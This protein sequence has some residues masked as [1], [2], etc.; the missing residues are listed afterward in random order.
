MKFRPTER[1]GACK[2]MVELGERER[3]AYGVDAHR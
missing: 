1:R 2:T 3:G